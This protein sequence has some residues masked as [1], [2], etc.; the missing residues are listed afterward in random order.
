MATPLSAEWGQI[1]HLY[2]ILIAFDTLFAG[3][4]KKDYHGKWQPHLALSPC[5]LLN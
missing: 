4:F 5:S 1:Y 2:T 3:K